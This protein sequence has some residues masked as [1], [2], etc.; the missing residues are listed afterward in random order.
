[1]YYLPI[2]VNNRRMHVVKMSPRI[3]KTLFSFL[4]D[5]SNHYDVF[6]LP[7]QSIQLICDDNNVDNVNLVNAHYILEKVDSNNVPQYHHSEDIPIFNVRICSG[8]SEN[9]IKGGASDYFRFLG[10]LG[11]TIAPEQ[12]PFTLK[13][14]HQNDQPLGEYILQFTYE[15]IDKQDIPFTY[16][17][18]IRICEYTDVDTMFKASLD[19]GSEASQIHLSTLQN[20]VIN[21]NI[22]DAFVDI[23]GEDRKKDYWQGRKGDDKTLYKSIYHIHK[24]P[25]ATNFGDM[26]MVNKGNNFL[27]S[28]LPID[29]KTN[30]YILLP[31]LKLVE[32][33]TG[34]LSLD[35]ITF[36]EDGFMGKTDNG[37]ITANLSSLKLSNGILRQILCNFLAVIL[38]S[39][40]SKEYL[41]FI[42]LVP[43]V[44][45]QEKV[46]TLVTGLYDDFNLLREKEMFRCYKGIEVS[47]VSES[48][49]SFFG[50]RAKATRQ[51]L[52]FVKDG[53]YLIIDAG[54]GTIDFS[55]ISQNGES[56][57]NY[58]SMYRSG[59][60][61]S[62]HVLT[63]AFYE[64][65]RNY[66]YDLGLGD[67]FDDIMRKSSEG[68]DNSNLL[69]FVSLLEQ[70]KIRSKDLVEDNT[71]DNRTILFA[72]NN[73]RLWELII[74]LKN[75]LN[76][77]KQIPG[78][79]NALDE[80][81][82]Q[83]TS[84]LKGSIVESTKN[85]LRGAT[86][87]KVLLT[88]RAFMLQQFREAVTEMLLDNGLIATKNDVF[89]RDNFTKSI[90]TYGAMRVGEQSVVN[91]NSNMLG[92]P[93]LFEETGEVLEGKKKGKK[94]FK[95]WLRKSRRID[96]GIEADMTFDLFYEGYKLCN[97]RNGVFSLNGMDTLVGNGNRADLEVYYV[98]DGYIWKHAGECGRINLVGTIFKL[99]NDVINRLVRESTF[100]FGIK[101]FDLDSKP[102][103]SKD[104]SNS[105]SSSTT[106]DTP[107]T[108]TAYTQEDN[109]DGSDLTAYINSGKSK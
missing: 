84:L 11:E 97:V 1:M 109:N 103:S 8:K 68:N 17:G 35:N 41:H 9:D 85:K 66:F 98:G 39:E 95:F 100:P 89:Y 12:I 44:Y 86:C 47:I 102:K 62:G 3:E 93:H 72:N 24:K 13:A 31:N 91:K 83:M 51:M 94:K 58:S 28:L 26:P 79:K 70:F 45:L 74:F 37:P 52:P 32:Q 81:I 5:S 53:K 101:S 65:L 76:E 7:S 78:M 104:G 107:K 77:G 64:A 50:V 71:M 33:L 22:R 36:N 59:I 42:L 92:S 16:T 108:P 63:Y 38:E 34:L 49:A 4:V 57:A 96:D 25:A 48:D 29:T 67:F 75:V 27:Q 43:N 23:V 61:A 87:N 30:D 90:S 69:E 56:L 99:D 80:K 18:A 20:N 46:N 82:K 21:M 55:L 15:I 60:P 19:F 54:K 40:K 105:K 14:L 106:E 2:Y 73:N 10:N 88:G 6:S